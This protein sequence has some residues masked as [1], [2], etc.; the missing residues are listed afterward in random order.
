MNALDNLGIRIP[1]EIRIVGIDDV[2]YAS[3]LRVPLTTVHQPCRAIG[4]NAVLAMVERLANPQMPSR[5]IRLQGHLVIRKSS[6]ADLKRP[7]ANKTKQ[8]A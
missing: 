6:G 8:S 4:R 1:E 5:D 3:L 7:S 2:R